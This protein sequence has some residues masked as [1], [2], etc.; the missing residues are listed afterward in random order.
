[1]IKPLQ[2]LIVHGCSFTFGEELANPA[3]Q[4]WATHLANRLK[5]PNVV[6]LARP[7]YSN[8]HVMEDL[9]T[10]DLK[11]D[12]DLVVIGFT[13]FTRLLFVDDDGWYTTIPSVSLGS[14]EKFINCF[15]K[16]TNIDWL[17]K[18]Y[19]TQ[20]LYIQN[21]LQTSHVKFML[22]N[23]IHNVDN[24]SILSSHHELVEKINKSTFIGW[25]V[26]SFQSLIGDR[27]TMPKGHPTE[28]HHIELAELLESKFR[29]IYD[30][31]DYKIG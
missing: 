25:P 11:M 3:E 26:V 6:N 7:A 5:I 12:H 31:Y 22:F 23:S 13:S 1:M 10:L 9:L 15:F 17:F 24:N 27:A 30:Y 20:I 29:K 16:Q 2:R 4:C 8:D 19:L 21:Y 18:R 14:R 28:E